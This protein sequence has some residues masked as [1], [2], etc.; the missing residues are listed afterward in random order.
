M[1]ISGRTPIVLGQQPTLRTGG[2]SAQPGYRRL[3]P[4]H[5]HVLPKRQLMVPVSKVQQRLPVRHHI[6]PTQDIKPAIIPASMVVDGR[7][8]KCPESPARSE[9]GRGSSVDS[10]DLDLQEVYELLGEASEASHFNMVPRKRERLTNLTTEEKLNRRKMKNRVAAQSAR[11]RKKERTGKL[12]YMLRQLVSETKYLRV[13][14][15]T[16]RLENERLQRQQHYQPA[17]GLVDNSTQIIVNKREPLSSAEVSS[18]EVEMEKGVLAN[19]ANVMS[20]L[21]PAEFIHLSPQRIGVSSPSAL[22][23]QPSPI[24]QASPSSNTSSSRKQLSPADKSLLTKRLLKQML[25]TLMATLFPTSSAAV[26]ST[27]KLSSPIFSKAP[28]L[29]SLTSTNSA[30]RSSRRRLQLLHC[31][32]LIRRSIRNRHRVRYSQDGT[33]AAKS[34]EEDESQ[35]RRIS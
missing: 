33:E 12:E 11:D 4:H 16:L 35:E 30:T 28:M 10:D 21:E 13:E 3:V 9:R 27:C 24:R 31:L 29:A 14:N 32:A 26:I 18:S 6:L 7:K 8:R 2:I 22:T 5:P 15:Q 20:T 17:S 1:P 19:G 34:Q 25:L 23:N